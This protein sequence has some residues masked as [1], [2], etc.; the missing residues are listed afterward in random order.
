MGVWSSSTSPGADTGGMRKLLKSVPSA[1]V[2]AVVV[3]AVASAAPSLRS[4]AEP[5]PSE[6]PAP[7]VT[8]ET[9]L[10][11]PE[12]EETEPEPGTEDEEQDGADAEGTAPDFSL[13]EG[14]GLDNAICRHDKLLV[15]HPEN[16]GLANSNAQLDENRSEHEGA[17]HETQEDADGDAA[18]Q[19]AGGKPSSEDPP[20][21][22]NG[23]GN[24][25]ASESG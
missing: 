14:T 25:T 21:K 13:C 10:E 15:V 18:G 8:Q 23:S 16:P 4:P 5:V 7:D 12:A 20:G 3:A 11:G 22:G 9:E 6:S 17:P 1:F 24:G 19:D 2:V